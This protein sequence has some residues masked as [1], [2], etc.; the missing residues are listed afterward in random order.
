MTIDYR[1]CVAEFID[2]S[3]AYEMCGCEDCADAEYHAIEEQHEAG[4]ISRDEALDAHAEVALIRGEED[5]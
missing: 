3:Y 5:W 4:Y 1:E 2:G